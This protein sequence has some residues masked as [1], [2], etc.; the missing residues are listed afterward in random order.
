MVRC[1]LPQ[2][3]SLEPRATLQ[4]RHAPGKERFKLAT[5]RYSNA[6]ENVFSVFKRGMAGV[7][8]HC[9][10]AHLRRD[11]SEFEFRRNRR[12]ALGWTD[13][14]RADDAVRGAKGKQPR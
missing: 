5:S 7:Y 13:K 3:A 10:E 12:S 2:A 6:V 1:S 9:G 4:L 8:Q 11:L 14:Q